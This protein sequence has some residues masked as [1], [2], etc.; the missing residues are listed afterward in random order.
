MEFYKQA[1]PNNIVRKAG[2]MAIERRGGQ[3][4]PVASVKI[5]CLACGKMVDFDS[6]YDLHLCPKCASRRRCD[7]PGYEEIKKDQRVE[8]VDV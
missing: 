4:V 5:S 3:S 2:I 7:L 6:V 1:E 8:K